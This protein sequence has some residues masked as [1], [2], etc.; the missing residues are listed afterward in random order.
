MN[1]YHSRFSA[2]H[3]AVPQFTIRDSGI[4]ARPGMHAQGNIAHPWFKVKGDKIYTTIHN[5]AGHSVLPQYQ[6][7]GNKVFTTIHHPDGFSS[8]PVYTIRK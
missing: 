1:L 4:Y 5:P 3:S 2:T 6:I 8:L 7:R